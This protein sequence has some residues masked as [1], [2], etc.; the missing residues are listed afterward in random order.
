MR[1]V[2]SDIADS[3]PI[4]DFVSAEYDPIASDSVSVPTVPHPDD[5]AHA[6][7]T[8]PEPSADLAFQHVS[9]ESAKSISLSPETQSPLAAET[10]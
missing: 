2:S 1:S 9:P 3:V 5:P 7:E 6:V 8:P 4:A 10:L